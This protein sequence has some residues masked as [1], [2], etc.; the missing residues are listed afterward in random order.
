MNETELLN[1][2]PQTDDPRTEARMCA[3]QTVF[4]W[5]GTDDQ[6]AEVIKQFQQ[7][8][9][10]E[11]NAEVELFQ[12]LTAAVQGEEARFLEIISAHL[13]DGWTVE[14]LDTTMVSLLLVAVGELSTQPDTP[15]A[16]ILEEYITLAHAFFEPSQ[17]KFVHGLLHAVG[18]KVR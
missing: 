9:L 10:E 12:A 2:G 7:D 14:K 17:V 13:R 5:R 3:I 11:R 18:Q 15:T 6:P 8:Q 16:V 1:S 4:Q